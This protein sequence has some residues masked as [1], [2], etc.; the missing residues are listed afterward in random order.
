M[1]DTGKGLVLTDRPRS[2][3]PQVGQ[4]IVNG[5]FEMQSPPQWAHGSRAAG[6]K[7]GFGVFQCLRAGHRN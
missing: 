7:Q 6:G 4:T 5:R 3:E 1:G 2:E